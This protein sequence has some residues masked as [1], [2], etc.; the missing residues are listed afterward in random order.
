MFDEALIKMLTDA[1]S[2]GLAAVLMFAALRYVITSSNARAAADR[3]LF[4]TQFDALRSSYEDLTRNERECHER[5]LR[6]LTGDF[7]LCIE[8]MSSTSSDVADEL[9][10]MRAA[11]NA[12]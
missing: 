1:G 11:S 12:H 6:E 2:T 3:E 4:A 8:R 5:E 9:R 10:R 7:K